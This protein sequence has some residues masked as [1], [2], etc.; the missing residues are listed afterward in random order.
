[1]WLHRNLAERH[2]WPQTASGRNTSSGRFLKAEALQSP[3]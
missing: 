2:L 3:V 1:V